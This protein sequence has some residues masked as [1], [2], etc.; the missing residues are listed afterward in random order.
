MSQQGKIQLIIVF[1][2]PP[3]HVAEGDSIFDSHA[4]FMASTHHRDGDKALLRYNLSKG[5]ELANPLDPGSE[6]TGNT[7]FTIMETY[8]SGAGVQDHWEQAGGSWSDLG[9]LVEWAG[10]C[11][12]TTVHRS[13]IVHS[14]W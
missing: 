8:E 14:L 5:P 10:K 1:S 13:P 9:S 4:A 3:E 7:L 2:C 11:N 12:V 6:E